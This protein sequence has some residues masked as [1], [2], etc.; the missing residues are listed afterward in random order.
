MPDVAGQETK[1]FTGARRF[2]MAA[3]FAAGALAILPRLG[4]AEPLHFIAAPLPPLIMERNGQA[5]GVVILAFR[6]LAHRMGVPG[7]VTFVPQKRALQDTANGS[8]IGMVGVTRNP[9][10]ESQY[11]WVGPLTRD[12][13]VLFT[14]KKTRPAPAALADA[15]A[16]QVGALAG[17][18]TVPVLQSA[19]FTNVVELKDAE[20]GARMLYGGR[21]DAWATSRMAGTYIVKQ[22]RLKPSDLD[23]G[24]VIRPNNVFIGFSP[25]VPDATI[26]D[27]QKVLDDLWSSGTIDRLMQQAMLDETLEY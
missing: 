5:D 1:A 19:G 10:R 22:L 14:L 6:E 23:T 12:A 2:R 25:D 11:K 21:L 27:W 13:I 26:L 9:E 3:W 24:P 8:Q 4:A 7:E 17:G 15:R 16:W 18:A 20:T